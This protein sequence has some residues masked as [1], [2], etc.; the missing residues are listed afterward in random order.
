MGLSPKI[1][2]TRTRRYGSEQPTITARE[3]LRAGEIV[4]CLEDYEEP[5]LLFT[6]EQILSEP[7]ERSE[8][9]K[10]YS[11]MVDDD[12]YAS[13]LNPERDPSFYFNHSCDPN[14]GYEPNHRLIAIRDVAVGEELCYDYAMTE[15][16][17]SFHR[18]LSCR[19]GALSCRGVLDFKQWRSHLFARRYAGFMSKYI[20]NKSRQLSWNDPRIYIRRIGKHNMGL[21]TLEAIDKG[22]VLLI[23]AGKVVDLNELRLL[24]PRE[25]ALSLQV[26]ENLWQ[27]PLLSGHIREPG[28]YINHC[29]DANGG[30]EDSTTL[31]AVRRIEAGEQVT[32]DYGVVNTGAIGE[33]L[34]DNFHCSC[35][36]ENC[37]GFVSSMD[38][39]DLKVVRRYWPYFPHFMKTLIAR[40]HLVLELEAVTSQGAG[41]PSSL[42]SQA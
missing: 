4:W 26:H 32:M 8:I 33:D 14:C 10:R 15:T 23:F 31:V 5:D 34:S 42:L 24:S 25:R 16:E 27:V 22:E 18:G 19:C 12:L 7:A 38:W 29:C 39:K 36:S 20:A 11:Y 2:V 21:F 6:R 1:T 28:D 3:A 17:A 40:N 37:R 41:R 30:M 9:L 13:T 35:G